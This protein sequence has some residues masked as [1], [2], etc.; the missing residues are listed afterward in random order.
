MPAL[1]LSQYQF[2]PAVLLCSSLVRIELNM[3]IWCLLI[4]LI[5]ICLI[6]SVYFYTIDLNYAN[7]IFANKIFMVY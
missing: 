2:V 3:S 6:H 7:I 4:E 5:N 1:R